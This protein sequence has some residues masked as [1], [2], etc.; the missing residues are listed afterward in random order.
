GTMAT[1]IALKL[2]GAL[3]ALKAAGDTF[4]AD[5]DPPDTL[6]PYPGEKR[7]IWPRADISGKVSTGEKFIVEV[8]DHADPARSFVKYWPLLYAVEKGTYECEPIFFMEIT[9]PDST[10]GAGFQYLARFVGERFEESYP[11]RFRFG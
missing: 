2:H 5:L 11:S 6:F 9:S 4:L 3:A 7:Q 8:D 1:Q 10:F